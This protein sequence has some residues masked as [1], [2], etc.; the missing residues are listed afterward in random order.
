MDNK[1]IKR[2][3]KSIGIKKLKNQVSALN[4]LCLFLIIGG[5]STLLINH[6][7]VWLSYGILVMVIAL[8]LMGFALAYR[9]SVKKRLSNI[10]VD[11]RENIVKPLADETFEDGY[12][13]SKS[14]M[15]QREIIN[16][17]MFSSDP[18]YKYSASN[19]LR[20]TYKGVRFLNADILEDNAPNNIQQTGRLFE[21]DITSHNTKP[22]VF[23]STTAAV[24]TSDDEEFHVVVP[25]NEVVS[26]MFRVYACDEQE[27]NSLLTDNM[28]YKLRQIVGLQLGKLLKI[29][30]M[31]DKTYVYFTTESGTYAD[32]FTKRN[33]VKNELTKVQD[34][35]N[36]I[37]K[38]IDIL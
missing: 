11:Y 34:T 4:A 7:G 14:T 35:F 20:G 22:V 26:R 24:M 18:D 21:F 6:K 31:G 5:V 19:E 13:M 27:M 15:T 1:F 25:E 10:Q 16:T 17:Y 30:F 38:L 2:R 33:D 28:I 32:K 23:T 3:E 36:V 12:F 9:V 8:V 37:G 29:S